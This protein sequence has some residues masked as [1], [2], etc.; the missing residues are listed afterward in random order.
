MRSVLP[1]TRSACSSK[2]HC[3]DE[4]CAPC[5][6]NTIRTH[7]QDKARCLLDVALQQRRGRA[8]NRHRTGPHCTRDQRAAA[9]P[10]GPASPTTAPTAN[11]Q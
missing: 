11:V 7:A 1:D 9:H 5:V 4:F 10:S 2:L 6:R 8:Q 3:G